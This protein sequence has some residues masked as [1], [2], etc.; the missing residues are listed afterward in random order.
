MEI[1]TNRDILVI[2]ERLVK[3]EKHRSGCGIGHR[4]AHQDRDAGARHE[5]ARPRLLHQ[6]ELLT[7]TLDEEGVEVPDGIGAGRRCDEQASNSC[8]TCDAFIIPLLGKGF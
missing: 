1:P 7:A 5:V 4:N 2:R 8:E 6:L 3:L